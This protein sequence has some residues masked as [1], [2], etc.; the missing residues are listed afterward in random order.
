M[1]IKNKLIQLLEES[2][3]Q[4]IECVM[5]YVEK[6]NITHTKWIEEFRA[7]SSEYRDHVD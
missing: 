3:I 5:K 7:L 6:R 4:Q 2:T 1:E